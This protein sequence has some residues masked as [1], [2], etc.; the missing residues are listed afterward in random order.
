M[1]TLA[2]VNAM[3]ERISLGPE[4]LDYLLGRL[5]AGHKLAECL[6][7]QWAGF[8]HVYTLLPRGIATDRLINFASGG[9]LSTGRPDGGESVVPIP[10]TDSVLVGIIRRHLRS[11]ESNACIFEDAVAG[12]T[13][14]CITKFGATF[15]FE[16][17]VY[18]YLLST[19]SGVGAIAATVK[20]AKS[21]PQFVGVLTRCS[22][23]HVELART[24]VSVDFLQDLARNTQAVIAGAFD[25]ESYVIAER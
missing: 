12:R 1:A 8:Q 16:H 4:G 24:S 22:A 25:G 14:S 6:I 23:E 10:N 2:G 9:R 17:E 3:V 5:Q 7:D 11:H 20:A 13:D 18:H 15:F 21:I 19:N